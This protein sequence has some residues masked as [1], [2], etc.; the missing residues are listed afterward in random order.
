MSEPSNSASFCVPQ[1]ILQG[2]KKTKPPVYVSEQFQA[3]VQMAGLQ[4]ATSTHRLPFSPDHRHPSFSWM[5]V[6]H[7]PTNVFEQATTIPGKLHSDKN[8][9]KILKVF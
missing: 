3:C 7:F 5:A 4:V 1:N 6:V 8:K 9:Q 2:K